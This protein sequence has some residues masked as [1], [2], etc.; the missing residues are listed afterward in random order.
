MHRASE[1]RMPKLVR[2]ICF[3]LV[4][5]TAATSHAEPITYTENVFGDLSSNIPM[6]PF[7]L[8]VGTNTIAGRVFVRAKIINGTTIS[9]DDHDSFAFSIP[10]QTKLTLVRYSFS[11]RLEQ[12]AIA[13]TNSFLLFP[14]TSTTA[15][16]LDRANF[17]SAPPDLGGEDSAFVTTLPLAPR[18]Y[19][20]LNVALSTAFV[21]TEY[22][23][24]QDYTWSFTVANDAPIPE[25]S[26]V[27]LVLLAFSGLGAHYWRERGAKRRQML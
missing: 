1:A 13:A 27:S 8:D 7:T 11:T 20:L 3:C 9:F 14:T 22:G 26:T 2:L 19:G 10:E 15:P 4:G 12:G 25:P 21:G 18:T 16:I 23:W 17:G 6:S 5:S 24:I